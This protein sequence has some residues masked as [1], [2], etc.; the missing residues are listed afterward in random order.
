MKRFQRE[1]AVQK[2]VQ[3]QLAKKLDGVR[4]QSVLKGG[5]RELEWK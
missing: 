5:G 3:A 4:R 1:W 2:K